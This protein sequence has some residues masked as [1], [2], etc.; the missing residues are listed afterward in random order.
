MSGIV[1]MRQGE[2]ALDVIDRVKAKLQE[3]EPG[4]PPGVKIV[5]VYDRSELILRS[6]DN[7]KQT[8]IEEMIIVSLVIL[9]FLWHFP[10]AIIPVFTIPIAIVISFIPMRHDGA[11]VE[12]HV[13]G[14]H[15]DCDRRDGGRGDRGG[16]ADAQEAGGVGAHR[17]ARKTTIA[18]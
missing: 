9:I 12:H 14:R 10:S 17:D 3:I 1:V 8:L 11:H 6:I 7:L 15:R 16:G 18:W 4:L 13:A 5:R 2:N